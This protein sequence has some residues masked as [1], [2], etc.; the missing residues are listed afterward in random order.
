MAGRPKKRAKQEDL[1]R[2]KGVRKKKTHL[3]EPQLIVKPRSGKW[4]YGANAQR[5]LYSDEIADYICDELADGRTLLDICMDEYVIEHKVKASTIRSWAWRDTAGFQSKYWAARI[6][7]VEAMSEEILRIA[8]DSS[9]DVEIRISE[10]GNKYEV[11]NHDHINRARL[12]ID[13]RKFL[14]AKI[15]GSIY[16]DKSLNKLGETFS[17]QADANYD[18][19]QVENDRMKDITERFTKQ[20]K[21]VNATVSD[22]N[23]GKGL[24][25][26]KSGMA[27][28][29][30]ETKH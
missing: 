8:D 26:A 21:I 27:V 5:T 17:E 7:G 19:P 13:T 3:N 10:K 14:L 23:A 1:P 22:S 6:I 24:V 11:V 25:N 15:V 29:D 16:G 18:T 4:I 9:E 12:R 2:P 30:G 20:M 28:P